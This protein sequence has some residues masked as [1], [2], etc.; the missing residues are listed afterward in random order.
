M[1]VVDTQKSELS[2]LNSEV[3]TC[4]A[5]KDVSDKVIS[6]I[7][8]LAEKS[9]LKF[10]KNYNVGNNIKL[11]YLKIIQDSDLRLCTPLSISQALIDMVL[12]GLE[13]GKKQCYFFKRK[14]SCVLFRSYFGDVSSAKRTHLVADIKASCVYEGDEFEVDIDNDSLVVTKHHTK[15]ENLDK[16]I[17]GAYAVAI[18]ENGEKKYC[19]MTRKEI[20]ANW[21]KSQSE[22]RTVHNEFPQEMSKRTVIRRLV[23]MIFNGAEST[24]EETSILIDAFN[25]TTENEY[26]EDKQIEERETTINNSIIDL[27]EFEEETEDEQVPINEEN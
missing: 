12:Q 19:V 6:Q 9:Q 8:A 27:E 11:A 22:K 21:N 2:K 25:R 13:I 26:L 18:M 1:S 4:I 24:D 17:V 16:P 14:N 10:P 20:Q 15:F 7:Q 23:K 3:A 5:K